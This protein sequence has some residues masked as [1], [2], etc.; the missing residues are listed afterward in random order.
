ML[1][2]AKKNFLSAK[3][4]RSV[5]FYFEDRFL[6]PRSL[7]RLLSAFSVR[8]YFPSTHGSL[9]SFFAETRTIFI[10]LG[11]L[12]LPS[13][14]IPFICSRRSRTSFRGIKNLAPSPPTT[15]KGTPPSF[16]SY[17]NVPFS[18]GARRAFFLH[19]SWRTFSPPTPIHRR[20]QWFL[21]LV[22]ISSSFDFFLQSPSPPLLRVVYT[23]LLTPGQWKFPPLCVTCNGEMCIFS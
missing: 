13:E 12:P 8:I 19:A 9:C 14:F 20:A 3:R 1:F 10:D 16:F 4:R 18:P 5:L 6:F 2:S 23:K 21:R 22:Q 15:K 11:R 17:F 7:L